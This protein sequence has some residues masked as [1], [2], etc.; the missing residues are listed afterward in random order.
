MELDQT[1]RK[2]WYSVASEECRVSM[3]DIP[4]IRIEAENPQGYH[5]ITKEKRKY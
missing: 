2:D 4:E 3:D 1:E 5:T